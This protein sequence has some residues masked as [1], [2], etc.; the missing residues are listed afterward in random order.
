MWALPSARSSATLS[1]R[2]STAH[3]AMATIVSNSRARRSLH[4]N[5]QRS[6]T[7]A[8]VI[9]EIGV[10]A[11]RRR[12]KCAGCQWC[13]DVPLL[14]QATSLADAAS[15]PAC[16]SIVRGDTAYK[17]CMFIC[18]ATFAPAMCLMCRC[19]LCP[20]CQPRPPPPASGGRLV[21][22]RAP[23]PPACTSQVIG[24]H[25]QWD[26]EYA[27]CQSFC[28]PASSAVHCEHIIWL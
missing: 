9:D 23:P 11:W 18:S 3:C 5:R 6:L 1:K 27:E 15:A 26:S 16:S 7:L 20:F 10:G 21:P 14:P 12:C 19:A 17:A 13:G 4:S 22:V 28:D 24:R 25:R 2:T 8:D